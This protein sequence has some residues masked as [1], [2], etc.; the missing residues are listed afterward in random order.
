MSRFG[1][2]LR[3][4]KPS[5]STPEPTPAPEPVVEEVLMTPEKEV[6]TE[7]SPLEKMTKNELEEY[8]RE[9]GVELDKRHSKS[10][11]ISEIKEVLDSF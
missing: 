4:K 3:G 8:G 1:D 5:V 10:R 9:L 6:L 7:A 2:L 11:L